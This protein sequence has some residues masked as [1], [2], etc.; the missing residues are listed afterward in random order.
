MASKRVAKKKASRKRSRAGEWMLFWA[1]ALVAT[2]VSA[3]FISPLTRP[4]AIRVTGAA[5]QDQARIGN[6]LATVDRTPGLLIDAP[7]LEARLLENS[8]LA[9]ASFKSNVFGR[10]RLRLKYRPAVASLAGGRAIDPIG[11]VFLLG[12]RKAPNLQISNKVEDFS[13]ILTISDPSPLRRLARV[14]NKLQVFLSKLVGTLD[15]DDRESISLQSEG[16][17]VEFG[18]TSRLDQKV[19]VL[20]KLLEE[21]PQRPTKGGRIVLVDPENPVQAR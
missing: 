17:V 4:S 13:T 18:D 1:A 20:A 6:E 15:I 21:D 9:S 8:G 2:L 3:L 5:K 11:N 14:A 19:Q 10:A 12:A 7:A 16:L